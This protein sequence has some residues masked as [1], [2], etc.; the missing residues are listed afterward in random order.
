MPTR[1][2]LPGLLLLG[3]SAGAAWAE[4][5]RVIES[6]PRHAATMDG[7]RQEFRVR[8]S[9]PVDHN[10][11]RLL[12][13]QGDR[14]IRTLRPRLGAS[15]DTLYAVAGGLRPGD[16]VLQWQAR[17]RGGAEMTEGAFDFSVRP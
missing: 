2:L 17:P 12:V 3:A 6:S 15:P 5:M 14:T 11:S 7:N 16:Y 10:V 13:R 9:Q 4:P 1:R 8:F